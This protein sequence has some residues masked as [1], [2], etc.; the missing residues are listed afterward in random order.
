MSKPDGPLGTLVM[1]AVQGGTD[2]P[3]GSLRSRD[4]HLVCT[5]SQRDTSLR[6][7]LVPPAPGTS[8]MAYVLWVA[9]LTAAGAPRDAGEG[10]HAV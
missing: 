4:A 8:D 9:R 7:G 2:W 5:R 1:V 3:G 10:S 6:M